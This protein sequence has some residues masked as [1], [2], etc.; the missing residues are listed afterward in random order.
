MATVTP[1][2]YYK[3]AIALF[4]LLAF[5][6]GAY[7]IPLGPFG[8]VVAV[9]IAAAKALI[10][11]LFFMHVRYQSSLVAM[12]AAAG[13]IWLVIMFGLTYTDYWTR[14]WVPYTTW[15]EYIIPEPGL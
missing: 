7:Y 9:A 8:P 12:F 2:T 10:I 11:V 5:T 13:F 14:S 3:S 4:V 1:R 6:L 15:G